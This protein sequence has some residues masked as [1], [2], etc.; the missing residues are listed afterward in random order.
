M[1]T[2]AKLNA[3]QLKDVERA[4]WMASADLDHCLQPVCDALI[5]ADAAKADVLDSLTV[6]GKRS[7]WLTAT[8]AAARHGVDIP[9]YAKASGRV[10]KL[11][12]AEAKRFSA[13]LYDY[14]LIT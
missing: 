5:C 13:Q 1:G 14:T 6:A 9:E 12:D 4:L 3:T 7:F 2:P 10:K 8:D 11:V